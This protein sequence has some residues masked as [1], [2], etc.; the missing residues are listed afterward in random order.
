MKSLIFKKDSDIYGKNQCSYYRV[1]KP[2][3]SHYVMGTINWNVQYQSWYFHDWGEAR[4]WSQQHM[5]EISDF[6]SN[7]GKPEKLG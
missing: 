2:S 1:H 3:K 4:G 6:I 7:L 5:K